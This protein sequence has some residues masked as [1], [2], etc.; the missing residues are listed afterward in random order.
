MKPIKFN[1]WKEMYDKIVEEGCD[2]YSPSEELY[3]FGYND[4]GS[5]A[6]YSIDNKE[7]KELSESA[8]VDDEYWGAY[9]GV[10]GYINDIGD[11]Y[12]EL[13]I[14]GKQYEE[15]EDNHA[16]MFCKELYKF[17]WYDTEEYQ[18]EVTKNNNSSIN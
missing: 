9:L 14:Q 5:I 3:V 8:I 17:E 12:E 4:S 7:A 10:G 18:V 11:D 1:N 16:F 2:L 6:Y 13:W 15:R